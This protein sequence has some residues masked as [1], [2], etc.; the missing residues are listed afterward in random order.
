MHLHYKYKLIHVSVKMALRRKIDDPDD[1]CIH[2]ILMFRHMA[3]WPNHS[4]QLLVSCNMLCISD[5]YMLR[6]MM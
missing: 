5:D 3:I 4:K 1:T 2:H 6:Y